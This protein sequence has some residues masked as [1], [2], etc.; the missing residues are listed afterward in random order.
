M[1]DDLYEEPD[2]YI[3]PLTPREEYEKEIH[4]CVEW[5]ASQPLYWYT[6]FKKGIDIETFA[7]TLLPEETRQKLIN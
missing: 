7:F 2:L 6:V 1:A 3:P 5:R 4:E